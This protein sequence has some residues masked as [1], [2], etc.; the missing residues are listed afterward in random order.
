M[1]YFGKQISQPGDLVEMRGKYTYVNRG[2]AVIGIYL[3]EFLKD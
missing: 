2:S 3:T 1:T